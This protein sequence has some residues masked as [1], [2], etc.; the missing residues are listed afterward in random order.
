[1][2]DTSNDPKQPRRLLKN[3]NIACAEYPIARRANARQP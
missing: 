2:T 1:M 3:R